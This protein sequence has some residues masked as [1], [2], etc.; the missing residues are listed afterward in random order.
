MKTA[1]VFG[2]SG[3]IGK[4]CTEAFL[5]NGWNVVST[6]NTKPD[7][8]EDIKNGIYNG[9]IVSFKC[10]VSLIDDTKKTFEMAISRFGTVD[11]VIN[12]SGISIRGLIQDLSEEELSLIINTNIRGSYNVCRCATETMLKNHRG[13]IINMSSMWGETGASFEVAY[14]MTKSA[15]IGLTKA[16]AKE[17]GPSGIRVNCISPGLIDTPMNID[18]DEQSK[19]AI[20]DDTPL[21]RMGTPYDVAS[22]AVFLAE[23]TSSFITGQ[24]IGVNG[25][26]VI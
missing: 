19:R 6:Y 23:D 11:A 17:V 8:L 4:A 26:Y 9:S 5:K 22:T 21:M 15:V 25:G 14:S 20:C 3:G 24:I 1:I 12:C 16:L 7:E 10:D 18:I 13:S 2:S